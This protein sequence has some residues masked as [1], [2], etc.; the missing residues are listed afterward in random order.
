MEVKPGT[1][2]IQ[3]REAFGDIQL[4]L[5]WA[6]PNPSSGVGQNRGKSGVFLMGR[7]EVQVLDSYNNETYADGQAA[8]LY[9]QYPP[10]W[11]VSLRPGE[12]QSYDIFFRRP[13]FGAGGQLLDP[14]RMTVLHN[15]VLVQN[16]ETLLGPT[17]WL[18]TSRYEA[19]G[20]AGPI[21]LQDH[22]TPVRFR[23]I[24][25][26]RMP[27][28]LAPP[29]SYDQPPERFYLLM[30][31]RSSREPT[32]ACQMG[33]RSSSGSRKGSYCLICLLTLL[34]STFSRGPPGSSSHRRPMLP[35]SSRSTVE[36]TPRR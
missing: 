14:A 3:T 26:R 5:E 22:D 9:G 1:G 25:V 24:W 30:N 7:Y 17:M 36:V 15:G 21:R 27:E 2:S 31:S 19:H 33:S 12:W 10:L 35:S 28:R 6:A 18:A 8:A 34:L 29:A 16:N 20:D 13:R 11:N 23:N 4:H 32:G